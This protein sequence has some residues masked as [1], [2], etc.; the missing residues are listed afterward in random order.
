MNKSWYELKTPIKSGVSGD[1]TCL[2]WYAIN[3][4]LS[5]NFY[6][7]LYNQEGVG[8]IIEGNIE[9]P[10]DVIDT[11]GTDDNVIPEWMESN[12]VWES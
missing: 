11:W 5:N 8:K 9:M 1:I 7:A 6:F 3:Y 10:Q 12:K 2:Q 4:P